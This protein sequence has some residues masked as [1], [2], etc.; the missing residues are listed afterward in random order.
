MRPNTEPNGRVPPVC[1]MYESASLPCSPNTSDTTQYE[2]TSST[3]VSLLFLSESNLTLLRMNGAL[4]W[5]SMLTSPSV[6][7]PPWPEYD[8]AGLVGQVAE[9]PSIAT[10]CSV[11]AKSD[12]IHRQQEGYSKAAMWSGLCRGMTRT[13]I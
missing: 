9:P 2:N 13:L 11:F 3:G 6:V 12:L 8:D 5:L 1:M 10:R 4:A 7:P